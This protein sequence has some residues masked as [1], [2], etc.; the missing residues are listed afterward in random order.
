[1][2]TDLVPLERLA[3]PPIVR[4]VLCSH[5]G[6]PEIPGRR[7]TVEVQVWRGK[8][9]TCRR[10]IDSDDGRRIDWDNDLPPGIN[11]T[12]AEAE[13]LYDAAPVEVDPHASI[14]EEPRG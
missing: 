10:R 4:E 5:P 2:T 14:G 12:V 1:M 7:V 9:V 6:L 13:A 3:L 11:L 8:K